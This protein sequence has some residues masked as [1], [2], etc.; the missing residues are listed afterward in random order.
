MEFLLA[1]VKAGLDDEQRPGLA[2]VVGPIEVT[3]QRGILVRD[4]A[5]R[6]C[7]AALF[8]VPFVASPARQWVQRSMKRSA[9]WGPPPSRPGLPES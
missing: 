2:G 5:E 9:V 3:R 7:I 8:I 6:E 4:D 1:A